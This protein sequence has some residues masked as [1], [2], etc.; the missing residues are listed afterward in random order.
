MPLPPVS[1]NRSVFTRL[2]LSGVLLLLVSA[3]AFAQNAPDPSV[4]LSSRIERTLS[5][6]LFQHL[7]HHTA[8]T[9]PVLAAIDAIAEAVAKF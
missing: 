5:A 4:S 3:P 7:N 9:A 1:F 8:D 2:L 6:P